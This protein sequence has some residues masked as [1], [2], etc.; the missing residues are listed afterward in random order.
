MKRNFRHT[1]K[2]DFESQKAQIAFCKAKKKVKIFSRKWK[3]RQK[4]L[5]GKFIPYLE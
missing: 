1:Q 3:K 4:N 5:Q 2:Y